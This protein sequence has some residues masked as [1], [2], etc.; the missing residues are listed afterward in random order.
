MKIFLFALLVSGLVSAQDFTFD[1]AS[2]KAVPSF[3]GELK[4]LKGEAY[5]KNGETTSPIKVG[6]RFHK[7]DTVITTN[8][9]FVKIQMIDDSTISLNSNSELNFEEFEFT[10]KNNRQMVISLIKGQ[11][12][13]FV[14]N[15]AT[16]PNDLRFK[17]KT[18]A[19]AV[20][21]TELLVNYHEEKNFEVSE[22]ALISGKGEV[23]D[24]ENKTHE[25]KKNN[26]LVVVK[27]KAGNLSAAAPS[28]LPESLMK[29]LL[30]E[31]SFLPYFNM[32]TIP[33]NSPLY[34]LLHPVKK[35]AVD[36]KEAARIKTEEGP[37]WEHNLQKLNEELKNNQK[38]R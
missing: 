11:I 3:I 23:T 27:Y 15:K 38:R 21:G 35:T 18:T 32:D 31:E 28:P 1:K 20:R 17:T 24:H 12:R 2:G 25:L 33:E 22:F 8:K 30:E 6:Q 16:A 34:T 26:R 4:L 13:S 10:D 37:G 9:T 36:E 19:M 7:N 14:K 29:Q 5:R